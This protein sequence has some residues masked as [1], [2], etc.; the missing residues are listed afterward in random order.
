[1]WPNLQETGHIYWRN[2]QRKTSIFFH[3]DVNIP[4]T[5]SHFAVAFGV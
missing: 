3:G 1:M 4:A 2:P 5:F